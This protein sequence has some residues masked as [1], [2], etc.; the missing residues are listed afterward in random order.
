MK[1]QKP[2]W[3]RIRLSDANQLAETQRM[4]R[5][6][7]LNTVCEAAACPNIAECFG[8]KTAT[9]MILG[10]VCTRN[11]TFCNIA[12]GTPEPVDPDEPAR[13]ARAAGQLGLKHVVVTSVTRDDLSDGGAA[14]FAEA[15]GRLETTGA[16]V[17]V[18]IPDFRGERSSLAR[19]VQAG[20]RVI[21][22]N[23]E[24]VSRLYPAVRPM[25]SYE[26]SLDLIAAL[27]TMNETIYAKSGIMLGLGETTKEVIRTLGDLR[28]AGCELLTIGQYLAPSDTHHPVAKYIEP[29]VFDELRETAL[30]MGF[31]HVAAGPLVRSS[32][33]AGAFG[34]SHPSPSS[35]RSP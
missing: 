27:K 8:R 10:A 2:D 11:C 18:L 5:G 31:F 30:A 3:L 14:H 15:I 23:M 33:R 25:A 6:L 4:L 12:G 22:H 24:T 35:S 29:A 26:R 19:V 28:T 20:P 1:K 9:F 7:S 34:L 16:A 17:E 21:N 32:Y 13:V